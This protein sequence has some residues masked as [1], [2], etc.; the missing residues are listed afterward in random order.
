MGVVHSPPVTQHFRG[1]HRAS[2][3]S[4]FHEFGDDVY[5]WDDHR[6]IVLLEIPIDHP[7]LDEVRDVAGHWD[8]TIED[9]AGTR[10]WVQQCAR[11]YADDALNAPDAVYGAVSA[12]AVHACLGGLTHL[13][14]LFARYWWTEAGVVCLSGAVTARSLHGD[15]RPRPLAVCPS[16]G[17]DPTAPRP[18]DWLAQRCADI[19]AA[20]PNTRYPSG[21]AQPGESLPS[22]WEPLLAIIEAHAEEGAEIGLPDSPH[23]CYHAYLGYVWARQTDRESRPPS[24]LA[25]GCHY[26]A[27]KAIP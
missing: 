26:R 13:A 24:D 25:I 3:S 2:Q 22:C 4:P 1:L 27:F 20:H 6:R 14:E 23:D 15:N 9:T 11:R 21:P 16:I 18:P 7:S 10:A 5:A 12:Q 8:G 19:A 17:Y